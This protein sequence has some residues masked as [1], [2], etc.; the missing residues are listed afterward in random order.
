VGAKKAI[1]RG[2]LFRLISIALIGFFSLVIILIYFA[3]TILISLGDSWLN[4][5]QVWHWVFA[6]LSSSTLSLL[7]NMII[8]TMIFRYVHDGVV[9]WKLAFLGAMVT[10][11]LLYSGHLLIRYYLSNFFFA[12]DGGI[13][14]SLLVIMVWVFY[15][16]QI[17]FFGAR[18][19]AVF[20]EKAGISL[21]K[22]D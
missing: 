6:S 2:I 7:S 21:F 3:Q 18:F 8:F 17:I 9:R 4:E 15:T 10:S 19:I 20:A 1:L 22:N 14:G 12:A 11:V 13:A 16:S 5:L